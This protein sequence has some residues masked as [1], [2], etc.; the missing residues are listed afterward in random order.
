MNNKSKR[1][2]IVFCK[3]C[4]IPGWD[5]KWMG[6]CSFAHSVEEINPTPCNR[7]PVCKSRWKEPHPCIFIH[8]DESK[9]QYAERMGFFPYETDES[10]HMRE[11]IL[12]RRFETR[13]ANYTEEQME[14]EY[15]EEMHDMCKEFRKM[16][17]YY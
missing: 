1:M 8:E 13:Y 9:E 7:R 15:M 6:R 12:N 3:S 16:E 4:T 10:D 11:W 14:D 5:C 2:N 17:D